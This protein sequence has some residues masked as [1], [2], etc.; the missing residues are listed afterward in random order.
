LIHFYK[1][2]DIEEENKFETVYF[3]YFYFIGGKETGEIYV[4]GENIFLMGKL[5]LKLMTNCRLGR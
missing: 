1:R 4:E 2:R 3:I 5:F